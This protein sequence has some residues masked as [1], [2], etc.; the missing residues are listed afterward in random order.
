MVLSDHISIKRG[1]DR[2]G[3]VKLPLSKSISNRVLILCGVSNGAVKAPEYSTAHDTRLL[4]GL[5]R[6]PPGIVDARDAGT[7]FRFLTAFLAIRPGQWIL[8]GTNRM[9][10]RPVGPLVDALRSLG[11]EIQYT[12]EQGFPPLRIHGTNLKGGKVR[13]RADIS[14]Q[15]ISALMMIGPTMKEGLEIHLEGKVLSRPYIRMTAELMKSCGA[16]LIF[17]DSI[18]TIEPGNYKHTTIQVEKDWSSASYFFSLAALGHKKPIGLQGLWK[19]S[20][21][22]DSLALDLAG[23][24]G[25]NVQITQNGLEILPG[26][27]APAAFEAD[28]SDTPDIAQ[29]F[30][31]LSAALGV[32]ARITGLDNLRIKETDRILAMKIEL[33]KM[34]GD[35]IE[36]KKGQWLVKPIEYEPRQ[37][38]DAHN[39]HRMAMAMA[40]LAVRFSEL[41]IIGASTV[42]KSFPEFWESLSELGYEVSPVS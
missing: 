7:A 12:H 26:G 8:T 22:G 27:E 2:E 4:Q 30:V 36:E 40:P 28:F 23:Q 11:A 37:A 25:V 42:I 29:T 19:N 13:V 6:E 5:L 34:G 31:F 14:S 32:E 9:R 3:S 20:L 15:F 17:S 10:Q 1:E 21:Q 35:L 18:I 24:F 38:L 33:R 16:E 39:D 41:E